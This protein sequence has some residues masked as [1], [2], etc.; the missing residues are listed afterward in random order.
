[1]ELLSCSTVSCRSFPLD[2]VVTITCLLLWCDLCCAGL[3]A[4]LCVGR[5]W[6]PRQLPGLQVIDPLQ[7]SSARFLPEFRCSSALHFLSFYNFGYSAVACSRSSQVQ[8]CCCHWFKQ[9]CEVVTI[10]L[11]FRLRFFLRKGWCL[12][13]NKQSLPWCRRSI[14]NAHHSFLPH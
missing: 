11:G 14:I 12:C 10:S 7:R 2:V 5:S 4:A 1:V 6:R 9:G 8:V 13:E 3:R